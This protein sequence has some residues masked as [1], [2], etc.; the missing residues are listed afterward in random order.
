MRVVLL[1]ALYIMHIFVLCDVK[2]KVFKGAK[3]THRALD[4]IYIDYEQWWIYII[5]KAKPNNT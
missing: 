1:K 3:V 4:Y 5:E 2:K